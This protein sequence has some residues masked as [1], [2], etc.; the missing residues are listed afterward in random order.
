LGL[1]VST[2]K[3]QRLGFTSVKGDDPVTHL[4]QVGST[5]YF[6]RVVPDEL[7]PY[8]LT[9][10]GNPR[11]EFMVSLRTKDRAT[12]KERCNLEAVKHDALLKEARKKLAQGLPPERIMRAAVIPAVPASQEPQAWEPFASEAELEH[13]EG[14]SRLIAEDEYELEADPIRQQVAARVEAEL[15]RREEVEAYWRRELAKQERNAEPEPQPKRTRIATVVDR[16]AAENKPTQKSID[17]MVAVGVWFHRHVGKIAVED[18]TPEHVMDFKAKLLEVTS[19]AN[20]QTKLR[21]FNTLMRY[22]LAQRIIATNPANGISV[23]VKAQAGERRREY[24]AAALAAVFGSPVYSESFRPDAGAGEAAYWLPLLGLYTGARLNELGQLRLSDIMQEA[25]LDDD[26]AEQ[27]AWVIRITADEADGLTLKNV[28]SERRVPIHTDIIGLGFLDYVQVQRER[29]ERRV[30][31]ALKSDKYGTV[32]AAWSRWFNRYLRLG[33][34]VTDARV[35]FHSFR[36]SF[37]HYA[38]AVRIP[39]DV[40]DAITGHAGADA[41]DDYKGLSHPLA[42]LVDAMARYRVPGFKLPSPP[43]A[44]G[45]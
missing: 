6:R 14:L 30:F 18:I 20:A 38:R 36:H 3:N 10:T 34:G 9:R 40:H 13:H 21:N 12:A 11:S 19:Q 32:T 23:T 24:D 5:Y 29:G 16:W 39:K 37:K 22:A 42:P 2:G 31:P 8:F 33:C 45:P 26:D 7:R 17:R 25:Y 43:G 1:R 15:E 41:G 35:V 44:V 4:T 28:G 27:S